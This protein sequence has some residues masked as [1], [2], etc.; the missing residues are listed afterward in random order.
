METGTKKKR[1]TNV[2]TTSA[3]AKAKRPSRSRK[4]EVKLGPD[5]K[6]LKQQLPGNRIVQL[7]TFPD[8]LFH[9]I[10]INGDW[11]NHPTTATYEFMGA[12]YDHA[13]QWF[14]AKHRTGFGEY[15]ASV[16]EREGKASKR[17]FFINEEL[18]RKMEKAMA[19][20]DGVPSNRVIHTALV[21]YLRFVGLM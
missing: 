12:I 16:P 4:S 18:F 20:R 9:V 15:L 21:H 17:T 7:I 13:V 19:D 2:G 5:G 1:R 14:M 3:R 8:A 11:K 10:K 6:P